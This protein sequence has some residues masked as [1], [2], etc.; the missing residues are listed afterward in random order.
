MEIYDQIWGGG[1]G[2]VSWRWVTILCVCQTS[3]QRCCPAVDFVLKG[4]EVGFGRVSTSCCILP[5]LEETPLKMVKTVQLLRQPWWATL[6]P[7][8]SWATSCFFWYLSY[9]FLPLK[10]GNSYFLKHPGK[11]L[12]GKSTASHFYREHL[13]FPIFLQGL[14]Y[15][16]FILWHLEFMRLF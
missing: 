8:P 2:E 4:C 14:C 12:S 11:R 6:K 13:S 9:D 3:F 10:A 5:A 15:N 16:C 7:D 1:Y